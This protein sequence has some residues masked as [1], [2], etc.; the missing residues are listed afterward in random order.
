MARLRS[1]VRYR[2]RRAPQGQAATPSNDALTWFADRN[3]AWMRWPQK[4]PNIE[5]IARAAQINPVSL[6][7]MVQGD[8]EISQRMMAALV[9]A[10]GERHDVAFAA[11]FE[12]VH[13]GE[14]AGAVA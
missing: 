8:N 14:L 13:D 3:P 6:L 4:V 2:L 10:S 1:A 12:L 5:A 9:W 11:M 7:K